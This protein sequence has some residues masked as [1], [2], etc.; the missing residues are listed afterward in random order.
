[1]KLMGS[2]LTLLQHADDAMCYKADAKHTP[3]IVRFIKPKRLRPLAAEQK[4]VLTATSCTHRFQ[5]QN[6]RR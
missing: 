6:P 3:A 4:A 2:E 1:M 5:N